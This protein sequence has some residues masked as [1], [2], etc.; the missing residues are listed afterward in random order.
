MVLKFSQQMKHAQR[1]EKYLR[2]I[3]NSYI[4]DGDFFLKS[5]HIIDTNYFFSGDFQG[6]CALCNPNDGTLS[7]VCCSS[8]DKQ[9]N[10]L[11]CFF[12]AIVGHTAMLLVCLQMDNQTG[13]ILFTSQ[14]LF[15]VCVIKL[16]GKF[17]NYSQTCIQRS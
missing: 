11:I 4:S 7:Y 15:L 16:T 2:L 9:P 1:T 13:K 8:K 3:F 10:Y 5:M 14:N 17:I 12:R 6:Q